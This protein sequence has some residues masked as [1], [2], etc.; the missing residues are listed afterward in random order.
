MNE[1][2]N[3]DDSKGGSDPSFPWLRQMPLSAHHAG[4]RTRQ[5][6]LPVENRAVIVS[7]PLCSP[8]LSVPGKAG[9][10]RWAANTRQPLLF[11][12]TAPGKF[13]GDISII[14]EGALSP[15]TWSL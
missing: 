14:D 11:L 3:L 13:D 5:A 10:G 7:L 15:Q 2:V 1:W 6:R 12:L 4:S 9:Q 8:P